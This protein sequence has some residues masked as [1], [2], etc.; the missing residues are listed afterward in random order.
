MDT[1]ALSLG[2]SGW[3][4]KLTTY[5]LLVPRL[6]VHGYIP[7]LSLKGKSKIIPML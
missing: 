3:D 6:S 4:V 2:V 5:L 7:P 1:G